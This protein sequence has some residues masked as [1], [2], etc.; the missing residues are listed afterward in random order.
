V[1]E[2]PTSNHDHLNDF[3]ARVARATDGIP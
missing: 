1:P 2:A 3:P